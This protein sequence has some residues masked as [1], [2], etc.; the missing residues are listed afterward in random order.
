MRN[1][2]L[3]S[4]ALVALTSCEGPRPEGQ[5]TLDPRVVPATKAG[6]ATDAPKP[7]MPDK[8]TADKAASAKP[9][10]NPPDPHAGAVPATEAAPTGGSPGMNFMPD[11]NAGDEGMRVADVRPDGAAAK[12]GVQAGDLVVKF[13]GISIGSLDD[14]MAVL[15]TVKV[16]DPVEIVV[17]RGNDTKTLKGTVGVSSR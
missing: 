6:A 17:K 9:V 10:A 3:L 12:A 16:G 15:Q 14:Y 5:K 8:A 11:Y 7:A 4:L 13:G 2:A 1:A